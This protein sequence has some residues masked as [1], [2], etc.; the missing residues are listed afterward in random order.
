MANYQGPAI[1]GQPVRGLVRLAARRQARCTR[2]APACRAAA[3]RSVEFEQVDRAGRRGGR[4]AAAR[5]PRVIA[6]GSERQ[7]VYY[8]FQQRGR[9]ITNEYLAKWFLFWD[10][11]TRNRS[12]GAL[13]R[14]SCRCGGRAERARPTP[15]SRG[16]RLSWSRCSSATCRAD[17]RRRRMNLLLLPDR[18][19]RGHGGADTDA[20]APRALACTCWTSRGARCTSGRCR[21]SAASPWRWARPAGAALG[22]DGPIAGAFLL[23]R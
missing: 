16:S 23:A 11:L 2:R 15:T 3:G 4:P 9:I 8:W 12:D 5:Q 10:S 19:G 17:D 14:W 1:S 21:G 22:A 18:G 13:V 20:R 7:L 6:L